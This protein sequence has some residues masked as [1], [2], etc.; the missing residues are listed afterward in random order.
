MPVVRRVTELLR[1]FVYSAL[2]RNVYNRALTRFPN[3][4]GVLGYSGGHVAEVVGS[5]VAASEY[6]SARVAPCLVVLDLD[7]RILSAGSRLGEVLAGAGLDWSL[8]PRLPYA[9]ETAVRTS[10]AALAAAIGGDGSDTK[11][12]LV[13]RLLVRTTLLGGPSG[14]CIAVS[15]EELRQRDPVRSAGTRYRLSRREREVLAHI[16]AGLEAR[17]IAERLGIAEST[18]GEY[19]KHL[20]EKVGARNRSALIAQVFAPLEARAY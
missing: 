6:L 11:V 2:T 13:G 5:M 15:L 18:V 10:A 3:R 20:N 14:S 9:V 8:A 17:E 19:F 7:Y 4:A 1:W 16:I 12:A